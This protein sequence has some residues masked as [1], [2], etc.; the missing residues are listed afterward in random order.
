MDNTEIEGRNADIRLSRDPTFNRGT[1][2][3]T[4]IGYGAMEKEGVHDPDGG[5]PAQASEKSKGEM[6]C[7]ICL[8]ED[9]DQDNPMISP[10]K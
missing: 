4:A 8:S 9:S 1:S 10:C 5:L 2:V 6:L 3:N 7:R